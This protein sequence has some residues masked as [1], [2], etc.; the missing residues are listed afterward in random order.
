MKKRL[1]AG[2][3][4][5]LLLFPAL[6]A[7]VFADGE[8]EL[9]RGYVDPWSFY[10][11]EATEDNFY[12]VTGY[13]KVQS[14]YVRMY[15][16]SNE[17]FG[18]LQYRYASWVREGI[19]EFAWHG[20]DG[21]MEWERGKENG[22]FTITGSQQLDGDG[23]TA[24]GDAI[25]DDSNH[26]YT[27]DY[28]FYL[29]ISNI[30]YGEGDWAERTW[31]YL[32]VK[33]WEKATWTVTDK[34]TGETEHYSAHRD[35]DQP[36]KAGK[37]IQNA[38]YEYNSSGLKDYREGDTYLQFFVD[39]GDRESNPFS[40]Y[41]GVLNTITFGVEV[42]G[43][44]PIKGIEVEGVTQ[45][46]SD[47]AGEDEGVSVPAA[48][49]VGI[50]GVGTALGAAA[51]AAG[52]NG[53]DGGNREDKKK[54]GYKMYVQKDFGDAIR[55]GGD[56]VKIRARMAEVL[57]GGAQQDR[58]DLTAR[59]SVSG[60]GMTVH[61]AALAGRY[62]EA[63]V[64]VPADNEKDSA[65][66]TFLFDGEGGQFTNSVVFR[67]VDGPSLAFVEE[68]EPGSGAFRLLRDTTSFDMIPGDGFTYTAL[69]MIVDAPKPPEL[70]DIEADRLA[71]FDISF[72]KTDRQAVYKLIVKNNTRDE[73]NNDIFAR[74][75]E[76]NFEIRVRVEGEKEPVTGYAGILLWPEGITVDSRDRGKKNGVD[77]VRVQ[78]YEKEYV[79]DLDKK[80]QV[81]EMKFT[82]AL[83]GEDKALVDPEGMQ[84]TFEK[85]KGADGLGSR[86]DKEQ[87]LAEKYEYEEAY[88][89]MND[90]FTYDFEPR[91]NLCE[92]DDGTFFM[93][94]LPV[95]AE[96]NGEVA[97]AE[98]PL[99]L[100]GKD[101]DPFEGWE[102]EY[103][104]LRERIEKFSLPDNKDYWLKK[105]EEV[106]LEPR[107]STVELR[108][109]SKYIIR[110]YMR[111][112]TIE[113]MKYRDEAA[114]YDV[115]ISWLEW[116]KFF[117]DCAFSLLVSMYAGPVAEAIIS[118]AKDFFA[119]AVGEV[120]AA[121]N[122]GEK[123]DMSIFDRFEFSKNLA[124]A[125]D[126]LVSSHIDLTNWKKAAATLGAYFVYAAFKNYIAKLNEGENDLYGA[127]VAAF[128]DMSVQAVKNGC[129][130]LFELWAKN[131][132]TFQE[133][134][135]PKITEYFRETKFANLEMDYNNWQQLYG[136]LALK[137]AEEVEL[138][139]VDVLSK[140]I[141]ELVGMGCSYI[142]EKTLE[143]V[144]TTS[145]F[146]FQDG[147]IT[148]SFTMQAFK[149][150]TY[151]VRLDVTN[152]LLNLSCPFFGWIYDFLFGS[153]P[154]SAGPIDPPKDPP[155]PPP[156]D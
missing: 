145:E 41:I 127:L 34:E 18:A 8:I 5:A 3:L 101:P 65:T 135:A 12:V 147:H 150:R 4:L 22:T 70:A 61:G 83:K 113:S 66:I 130:K 92:P 133:K 59:I 54:K 78:A 104:K 76:K 114:N 103:K 33:G 118:P 98:V 86:A 73:E 80:W 125:G 120:I 69:F 154:F 134:I 37:L 24:E 81:S 110:Q 93:V 119:G 14:S 116:A 7:A 11:R 1:F 99:R 75:K 10:T 72:E 129:A 64:S 122:Y 27:I 30:H 132:K 91:A 74:P 38:S 108:L 48:I 9:P 156:K 136:D 153:I 60:D 149:S 56:P 142:E 143:Q 100:R 111:Y 49:A 79:G 102:E 44:K 115:I 124:A 15:D 17:T 63:T 90:K 96:Y 88:G 40:E 123:I 52:Q 146:G 47:E 51:A 71:D 148:F 29:E 109:T 32:D 137:G 67:L 140:Y 43:I 138:K 46:A 112:W 25:I 16:V 89:M 152:I 55:R 36:N 105:L 45:V 28:S 82:L 19:G 139:L 23:K 117:G 42:V 97:E 121:V 85:L 26:H 35:I 151:L 13:D 68:T 106:A 50:V 62:C 2:I 77:Y 6:F 87:S 21:F 39:A 53:G 84:F 155:L 126:N 128:N 144:H 31:T 131:S 57:P 94:L 107:S 58:P 141:G 20:F 95:R